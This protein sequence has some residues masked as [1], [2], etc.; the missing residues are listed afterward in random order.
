[1]PVKM[2]AAAIACSNL[3]TTNKKD[4]RLYGAMVLTVPPICRARV[5]ACA[6]VQARPSSRFVET[7]DALSLDNGA[8]TADAY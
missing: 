4:H 3:K 5:A 2:R 8:H 7:G 1:M 6:L